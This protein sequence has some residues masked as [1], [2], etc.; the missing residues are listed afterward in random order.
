MRVQRETGVDTMPS[1]MTTGRRRAAYGCVSWQLVAPAIACVALFASG[2]AGDGTA[3]EPDTTLA[4]TTTAVAP[5]IELFVADPSSVTAGESTTLSWK[6]S[7]PDATLRLAPVGREVTGTSIE[8][9]PVVTTTYTLIAIN[10]GGSTAATATVRVVASGAGSTN[11][12]SAAPRGTQ[13]DSTQPH[14]TQPDDAQADSEWVPV[15]NNLVGLST[16]CGNLSFVS[17]HPSVD[18][19]VAG[20]A[21]NGLWASVDGSDTWSKLGEGGGT[22]VTNR[23]TSIVYDESDPNTWWESGI[24]NGP[25]VVKTTDNGETFAAL[26]DITHT[27]LVSIDMHDPQRLTM[28]AAR[29]DSRLIWRSEDAGV[30][31]QDI[32]AGLP[33]RIGFT[34]SVLVLDPATYLVGTKPGFDVKEN[35]NE[36]IYRTTNGGMSWSR[37]FDMPVIGRPLETADGTLHWL[38]AGG[39]GMVTSRDAGETWSFAGSGPSAD[40][41]MSLIELPEGRIAT[42]A[43]NQLI[44]SDDG[45]ETWEPVGPTIP[46]QVTGIAYAPFRN[47]FYAWY[48]DCTDEIKP[49]SIVR[50]DLGTSSD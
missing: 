5:S 35:G 48:F 8:I 42:T 15:A 6:V 44:T 25:G 26:G 17:A 45:G 27:E 2:C 36:G 30:S 41:A 23:A 39:Q 43:A 49:D 29:H 33:E 18:M 14:A 46:F 50:L 24:Y 11:P 28:L 47:A 1:R 40:P 9:Q 31:W 37:V 20:V 22:S 21:L 34:M 10:G 13:A 3:I 16:E 32:T 12:G 19:V 38:L 4:G 7:D